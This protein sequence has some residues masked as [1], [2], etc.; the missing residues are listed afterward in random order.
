MSFSAIISRGKPP[1]V[2]LYFTDNFVC[3]AILPNN[4]PQKKTIRR[5]ILLQKDSENRKS[6]I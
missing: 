3:N 6:M 4:L 1:V 2:N 5:G